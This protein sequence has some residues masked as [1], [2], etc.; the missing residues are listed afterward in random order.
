LYS[1]RVFGGLQLRGPSG[2]VAGRVAQ[3]R[4]LALLAVLAVADERGATRDQ[5]AGLL[6]GETDD[7]GALSHLSNA[8]YLIHR[9]VGTDAVV[10]DATQLRL[11]AA[12]VDSDIRAFRA[13]LE[14]H[15]GAAAVAAYAGPLLE[16]FHLHGAAAF[17]EWLSGE[18]ERL[19]ARY[20][21]TVERL[22]KEADAAGDQV[23]AAAWWQRLAALDPFNSRVAVSLAFALAAARDRVNGLQ[24][25]RAHIQLLREEMQLEPDA[26]VLAAERSLLAPRGEPHGGQLPF[27]GPRVDDVAHPQAAVS[28]R[29]SAPSAG[30]RIQTWP[31]LRRAALAL[32][33]LFV[34]AGVGLFIVRGH[35]RLPAADPNLIAV[36]PFR[37]TGTDTLLKELSQQLPDLLWTRLT[38]EFGPR[39]TDPA[40]ALQQWK[41]KGGTVETPLPETRALEIARAVGAG[42]LIEGS[43]SGTAARLSVTGSLVEVPSG[44]VRVPPT[45]VQGPYDSFPSLVDKLTNLLLA[46]DYGET[47]HRLPELA[48]HPTAAVQAYLRGLQASGRAFNGDMRAARAWLTRA[49]E[50]DSTLV[51]AVVAKCDAGV[52]GQAAAAYAWAHQTTL[53][54]RDRAF[55]RADVGWR[56][57]ATR[58]EAEWLAQLDSV[59]QL[60]PEWLSPIRDLATELYAIGASAGV[61]DWRARAQSALERTVALD[62][63]SFLPIFSL[64]ELALTEGDTAGAR[65]HAAALQPLASST[66]TR[67]YAWSARLR[68]ALSA[69]DTVAVAHL[70]AEG[71]V[72]LGADRAH[73]EEVLEPVLGGLLVDARGLR[74]LDGFV[75]ATRAVTPDLGHYGITWARARG[76]Y[77]DWRSL[78]D[79]FY[80]RADADP[81]MA[82]A[83]RLRDALFLGVP[84][85][86]SVRAAAAYLDRVARGGVHL[87]PVSTDPTPAVVRPARARCWS[88]LW[89][90]EH[91]QLEGAR[92]TVRYLREDVPL[93]YRWSVCAGLIGVLLAERQRG[94]VRGAL[95]RL[96]SIARPATPFEDWPA[97]SGDLTGLI[98]NLV[99]ARLL[100]RYGEAARALAAARRG[101]ATGTWTA[102]VSLGSIV[103]FLREEGRLAVTT[104]DTAGAMWAYDH[105]LALRDDPEPPWRA[106]RDSVRA[107]L[108]ALKARR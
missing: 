92:A 21:D 93:P 15:D 53:S 88:A 31:Q 80:G 55:L 1:L 65:R 57:G 75:A 51:L 54:P 68:L 6:W 47:L 4:P 23:A 77:H 106:Q 95:L 3:R 26:E 46:E 70:W 32:A 24:R 38:G 87:P 90:V 16:G 50:L 40:Y 18:R 29:I 62:A 71:E 104:G 44:A 61:A 107:E 48:S 82:A 11:N 64:F 86:S 89:H 25:L 73:V 76:R 56:F 85:D 52:C 72:L 83:W 39:T 14:R 19:A 99:L 108:A 79:M 43:L 36:L 2:P 78:R 81:V 37:V 49:F 67:P 33:V 103:D 66:T 101:R 94:D 100:P 5:L 22:A 63:K 58:T 12:S 7:Q 97:W 9:E 105:Y 20:A 102:D 45:S 91:G 98:D 41:A 34:I 35:A 13:A 27:S 17:E 8:L 30:V 84:E 28:P 74:E 42:R 10:G 69:A 96:D 60:A 59:V